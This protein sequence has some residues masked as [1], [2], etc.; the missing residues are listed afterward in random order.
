[1]T[2]KARSGSFG[3]EDHDEDA[4]EAMAKDAPAT[5]PPPEEPQPAP[6]PA[7]RDDDDAASEAGPPAR[8][9][10][11][12]LRSVCGLPPKEIELVSGSTV[13]LGRDS[14]ADVRLVD[15]ERKAAGKLSFVS[16]KHAKIRCVRRADGDAVYARA[17]RRSDGSLARVYVDGATL[18]AESATRLR[19]GCRVVVGSML[20]DSGAPY[21]RFAYDLFAFGFDADKAEATDSSLRCWR[22]W[23]TRMRDCMALAASASS[24]LRRSRSWNLSSYSLRACFARFAFFVYFV[25]FA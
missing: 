24:S 9:V 23:R 21:A 17:L 5:A 16:R 25:C 22:A 11:F 14:R 1:M 19:P 3:E 4:P 18:D 20:D 6:Q 13:L 15:H 10:A 8:R 7:R 2:T 12:V